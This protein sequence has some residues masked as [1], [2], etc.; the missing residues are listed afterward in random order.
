MADDQ[1]FRTPGQLI[2]ALM[3]ARG[4]SKRSFAIILGVSEA[5]VTRITTDKQGVDAKLSIVLEEL[6]GLPAERF[7]S[8]QKELELAQARIVAQPDPARATRALVFGELPISE[9]IERGWLKAESVRDKVAVES[10]LMR[11]FGVNRLDDIQVLP[12]AAH[13]SDA[14]IP[15]TPAQRRPASQAAP[16]R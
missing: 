16:P 3:Q 6:F 12:H 8:L 4:W 13:K 11:F 2:L 5:T 15:A 14:S 7:L 10:E 9:M 1:A